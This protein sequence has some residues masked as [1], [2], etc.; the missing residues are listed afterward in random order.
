MNLLKTIKTILFRSGNL[1]KKNAPTILTVL[2]VGGTIGS[3]VSAVKATPKAM[4]LIEE[5][6]KKE[7]KEKLT[8]LE[9][10]DSC[11]KVY[12]PTAGTTAL[13]I[14]CIIGANCVGLKQQAA[15]LG[16]YSAQSEML[17][18]YKK[19]VVEAIGP[20][21]EKDIQ[22]STDR[23]LLLSNPALDRFTPASP[24]DFPCFDS[25]T[26]QVFSSNR[27]KIEKVELVVRDIIHSSMECSKNEYLELMHLQDTNDGYDMGWN[28]TTGFGLEIGTCEIKGMP[29]YIVRY[30]VDPVPK[31]NIYS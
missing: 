6:K 18:E 19:K 28:E 8:P 10:V 4:I 14:A 21:Q 11:W 9:T 7:N 15:L 1:L 16:L 20:E 26:G 17:R 29:C 5:R 24:E 13:S 23:Q 31:F 3:V 2:G 22:L 30:E 27:E 12:L 25:M